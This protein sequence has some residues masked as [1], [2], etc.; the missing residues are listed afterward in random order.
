M[1]PPAEPAPPLDSP[2]PDPSG[3]LPNTFLAQL[4]APARAALLSIGTPQRYPAGAPLFHQGDPSQHVVIIES[5]WVKVT[6]ISRLG[7]E[8]LLAIRG[9]G[10]ILGEL[11]AVDGRPRL[12]T[13]RGLTPVETTVIAAD[14]LRRCL[15]EQ[16]EITLSLLRH[17]AASLREADGR[18]AEYGASNGDSRL[19]GL[20][21]EL[22]SRH[23]V[24]TAEG[25][26]IDLPLTQQDLAASVGASREVVARTLRILRDREIVLTRRRQIIVVR[27]ELLRSLARSVSIPTDAP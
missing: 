4:P 5:G 26:V 8:A 2:L 23:G 1:S 22:V 10:D 6:S 21:L 20:L 16:P 3:P 24:R 25:V 9:A 15:L 12:A 13:V 18:R 17:L 7:W 11:S 19:A 27:P 14:R